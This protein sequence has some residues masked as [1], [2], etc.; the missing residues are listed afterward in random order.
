MMRSAFLL[1][2]CLL[3]AAPACAQEVRT[4]PFEGSE[5]F[6]HILQYEGLQPVATVK[7]LLRNP[8]QT[9]I[10]VFGSVRQGRVIHQVLD[11]LG[12]YESLGGNTLI[13][14]DRTLELSHWGIGVVGATVQ[15]NDK[16]QAYRGD[17]LCPA[18]SAAEQGEGHD[19]PIFRFLR[20]RIATNHPSY[21]EVRKSGL[22]I[23]PLLSIQG[24]KIALNGMFGS[25]VCY[26]AGSSASAPPQGRAL[27]IA[28]H[29]VFMNGMMLQS[30][31]DNFNFA[32]NVV[33]WLREGPSGKARTK[34]MFIVDG[35]VITNFDVSLAP[36]PPVPPI[37]ALDRL[38]HGLEKERF[39]H[40]IFN[41]LIGDG[42]D[43]LLSVVLAAAT[44]LLL[45]YGAKKL[46]EGR[47][48]LETK[49]PRMVGATTALGPV[50]PV[51]AQRRNALFRQGNL[52]NEA[53]LL[54]RAW[55]RQ[56]FGVESEPRLAIQVKGWFWGRW[57]M[58]R[59]A[60][61]IVQLA[62][63][64][65]ADPMARR[66]FARLLR[67]LPRLS[68]ARR[69]GQLALLS[70]GKPVRLGEPPMLASPSPPTPLP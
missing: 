63:A 5:V 55:L 45:L 56:E 49:A 22:G 54:A 61:R 53:R 40:R 7:E 24:K 4:I 33:R 29:G 2:A 51:V 30:D 42:W 60:S 18:I 25:R 36:P 8:E 47:Y 50:T 46:L 44:F 57:T 66:E 12:H 26:I 17:R 14:T 38:L 32:I 28:G 6:C 69:G 35:R 15:Q 41:R 9:M 67:A 64:D 58:Q 10:I 1:M 65:R 11:D 43:T 52:G 13:A 31:N 62:A 21:L 37:K 3:A 39:F 59:Q 68:D 20:Q 70:N 48:L 16:N 34:A 23:T 19:H 27:F